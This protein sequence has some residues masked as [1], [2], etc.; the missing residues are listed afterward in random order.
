MILQRYGATGV[1]LLLASSP[2]WSWDSVAGNL[3][4]RCIQ[5]DSPK[6]ECS[7]SSASGQTATGL[8]A[9]AAGANL[10][11][12]EIK[13]YP[14]T[15]SL[16]AM[17]FV[18]D[19]SDPGRQPVIER[20]KVQIGDVLLAAKPQH[21]FGLASFDSELRMGA[22]V[23]STADQ[24]TTAAR[25]LTATGMTTELYRSLL[26]AIEV[27]A[28][29]QA[30]RR[31][32]VLFSD[33]QAEDQAYYHE[34]VIHA[35]LK[36]GVVINSLGFPRSVARSV[37]LQSLRRL[38]EET[39]GVFI[40]SDM[41]FD[42]PA[43]FVDRL[44]GAMDSGGR[45][46]VDLGPLR[47]LPAIA[48]EVGLTFAM[49]AGP[50]AVQVPLT[51]APGLLAGN[52]PLQIA[53][54]PVKA[55]PVQ[56]PAT[57]SRLELWLWYGVPI[58]LVVLIILALVT[59]LLIFRRPPTRAR[60]GVPVPVDIKPLAYLIGQ[61]SRGAR[62]PIRGEVWRIGRS[63][64]NELTLDDSSVSRRHAEIQRAQ[65]GKFTIIDCESTNGVF[66]NN[67]KIGRREIRD[68]DIIE[69]GDIVVRFS[70][71]P[72]DYPLAEDTAMLHTRAPRV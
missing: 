26:G 55:A 33:G 72:V 7:Y 36:A 35:A 6:L 3:Q 48:A 60:P 46:S 67:E 34:D 22:P 15:G 37:A 32:I 21:H 44:F 49:P 4:V 58:A 9:E 2:V 14:W 39:G 68:G 52:I 18:V 66:V 12:N 65:D 25:G 8:S 54:P 42:L 5:T 10:P 11:V 31:A 50:I 27:L 56:A 43:G 23:G 45:F 24:V 59:L 47:K 16:S 62:Y 17:L 69:I 19:T 51:A 13:A 53:M 57:R 20:N 64:D 1:L 38:S 41:Q 40:E 28:H 30:D 29:I 71:S 63:Q 61:D 70:A